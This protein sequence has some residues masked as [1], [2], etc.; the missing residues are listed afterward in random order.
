MHHSRLPIRFWQRGYA[1]DLAHTT[2]GITSLR[3]RP[4]AQ[5]KIIG[6]SDCAVRKYRQ[7]LI[8]NRSQSL[9]ASISNLHSVPQRHLLRSGSGVTPNKGGPHQQESNVGP[10]RDCFQCSASEPTLQKIS[11]R[12]YERFIYVSGFING[13]AMPLCLDWCSEETALVAS[14]SPCTFSSMY[15]AFSET[16]TLIIYVSFSNDHLHGSKYLGYGL[17]LLKKNHIVPPNNG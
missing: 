8:P 7:D 12:R 15:L 13:E 5:L 1:V 17:G 9:T 4:P 2:G 11:K 10:S 3:I 14:Q 6:E 16:L